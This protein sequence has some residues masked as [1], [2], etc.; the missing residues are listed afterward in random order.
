MSETVGE[1]LGRVARE[2]T[3]AGLD[4]GRLEARRIMAW[5]TGLDGAGLIS[6]ERDLLPE[7]A[8]AALEKGLAHRLARRPLAHLEG[9]THF[10][11]L[12]LKSDARALVPRSDSECVVDL[13]LEHLPEGRGAR[14]GDL[15]TGSGCLLLALLAARAL[16]TG[17]GIDQSAGA[18][19]LARENAGSLGLSGRARFEQVGWAGWSGW[20]VCDLI[21]ANPPY[22]ATAELEA[23]APEVRDHDPREAL[24]GGPDGLAAYREIVSLGAARMARGAVLVLETGHDQRAS[25]S[26]I[27]E[28]SG[29]DQ[30][31]CRQDLEGRDRAI[32]A[33][34]A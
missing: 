26:A 20:Q 29:F 3:R 15:G 17:T 23:L 30:L 19:A 27:L 7:T 9:W 6:R 16:A 24:D 18:I 10:R 32:C 8:R 14:I 28:S 5:A 31:A 12:R 4:E 33:L 13:A 21:I 1:A 34:R 11:G 2:L 22:I 25:V